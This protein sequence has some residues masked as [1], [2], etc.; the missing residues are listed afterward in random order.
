MRFSK[1]AFLLSHLVPNSNQITLD[2]NIFSGKLGLNAG[3]ESPIDHS[4]GDA[5]SAAFDA[6]ERKGFIPNLKK[7]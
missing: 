4:Q 3:D 2:N 7:E 1:S 5:T 6:S